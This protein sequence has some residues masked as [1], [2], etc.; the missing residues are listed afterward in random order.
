MRHEASDL[1]LRF[2]VALAFLYPPI[3]AVLNPYSWVGYLPTFLRDVAPEMVV[4][5]LF[6]VLEI[7]LA[8]WILSGRRIFWP[9][10]AATVILFAIVLMNFSEFEVLFRDLSI[11]AM[12]LALAI[13]H[14]HV[15][16]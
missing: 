5:H 4:L 8:V 16:T 12:T 14:R 10:V 9:S 2:G 15:R 3:D 6:G 7:I 1:L 11:A 13:T